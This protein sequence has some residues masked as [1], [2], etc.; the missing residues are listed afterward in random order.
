MDLAKRLGAHLR[1]LRNQQGLTL[2]QVSAQSGLPAESLSRFERGRT[3][4]S[5][6]TLE[7]IAAGLGVTLA[8]AVTL[9]RAPTE[10]G[11]LPPEVRGIALLVAGKAPATIEKA[12]RFVEL[13][14][15]LE[16]DDSSSD[17][18]A[19]ARQSRRRS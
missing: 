15:E 14:V 6:R 12:R 2:E 7:R 13:V 16:A 11:G 9:D 10:A 3:L 5:L 17:R 18:T 8:D 1:A 19:P 4:P